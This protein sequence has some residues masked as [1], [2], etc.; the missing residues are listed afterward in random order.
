MIDTEA[1]QTLTTDSHL[2]QPSVHQNRGQALVNLIMFA[3]SLTP[4]RQSSTTVRYAVI[5][6]IPR[7][8]SATW[9]SRSPMPSC[10]RRPDWIPAKLW[11]GSFIISHL[12]LISPPPVRSTVLYSLNPSNDPAFR[13]EGLAPSAKSLCKNTQARPD[14]RTIPQ[15]SAYGAPEARFTKSLGIDVVDVVRCGPPVGPPL[16]LEICGRMMSPRRV[17]QTLNRASNDQFQMSATRSFS[18]G[19]R[20]K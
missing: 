2:K 10:P 6:A 1:F 17:C 20:T 11:P 18:D 14:R 8:A 19:R 15:S 13:F 16:T 9:P 7:W 5:S 12:S 3:S 4:Y